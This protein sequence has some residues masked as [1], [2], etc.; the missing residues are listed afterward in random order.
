MIPSFFPVWLTGGAWIVFGSIPASTAPNSTPT[1]LPS[2]DEHHFVAQYAPGEGLT[3]EQSARVGQRFILQTYGIHESS[4][5][6]IATVKEVH[7]AAVID[8]MEGFEPTDSPG[9]TRVSE[10]L[11]MTNRR[12]VLGSVELSGDCAAFN[13]PNARVPDGAWSRPEGAPAVVTTS[14]VSVDAGESAR[15]RALTDRATA[16]FR[17]LPLW[18][19]IQAEWAKLD[20]A[21]EYPRWDEGVGI[22]IAT[23]R[24]AGRDWVYLSASAS[25]SFNE[26]G[27]ALWELGPGDKWTLRSDGVHP[28]PLPAF[29]AATDLDGDGVIEFISDEGITSGT[30]G[31]WTRVLDSEVDWIG[32]AC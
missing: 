8:T 3:V 27:W 17:K 22:S 11:Q 1:L 30:G 5:V 19:P 13:G 7:L 12:H 24:A 23:V 31:T 16:E 28:A 10:I 14:P 4:G 2:S 20:E 25:C 15:E 32:C 18:A 6:C 21:K 9:H 26:A 29:G